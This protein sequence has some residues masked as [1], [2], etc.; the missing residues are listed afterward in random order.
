MFGFNKRKKPDAIDSPFQQLEKGLLVSYSELTEGGLGW[1]YRGLPVHVA[2]EN[3]GQW[4][5]HLSNRCTQSYQSRT[6]WVSQVMSGQ[7]DHLTGSTMPTCPHCLT[8]VKQ[9]F[10]DS[11]RTSGKRFKTEPLALFPNLYRSFPEL[12]WH[13]QPQPG[14]IGELQLKT[15]DN[16][17]FTVGK[18]QNCMCTSGQLDD[19]DGDTLCLACR[20][21]TLDHNTVFDRLSLERAFALRFKDLSPTISSWNDVRQHLPDSLAGLTFWL[22]KHQ[23]PLPTLWLAY[24]EGSVKEYLPIA[25]P[26]LKRAVCV[27]PSQDSVPE[28]ST[29]TDWSFWHPMALL[30]ELSSTPAEE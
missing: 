7:F 28:S 4:H 6:L 1:T 17:N 14:A 19:L 5:I 30:Q 3:E 11:L 25:W 9:L 21:R 22:E 16:R 2:C 18:C 23:L 15:L 12:Y 26:E 8:L 13:E 10:C 24:Q 20:S 27:S 29:F